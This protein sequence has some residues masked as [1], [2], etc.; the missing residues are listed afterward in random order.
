M[1][2]DRIKDLTIHATGKDQEELAAPIH[3]SAFG[4]DGEGLLVEALRR[5]GSAVLDL[6]AWRGD[7]AV[8][9]ILMSALER[10]RNCLALAPL[11]VMPGEQGR[12]IG[13]ALVARALEEA[14]A[15]GWRAVFV[16]GDPAYYGRHGFSAAKAAAF[17]TPFPPEAFQA[18]ELIPGTLEGDGGP[19]VYAP[20]FDSLI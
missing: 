6:L 15:A 2:I 19:V 16:L 14:R 8:G 1:T 5:E 12:G 11:A 9:H 7:R 4:A 10:P 18:L 13:H 17:T 20:A 3:R